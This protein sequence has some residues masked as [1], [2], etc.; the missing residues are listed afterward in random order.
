MRGLCYSVAAFL[1]ASTVLIYDWGWEGLP[2]VI[3]FAFAGGVSALIAY[4]F[5]SRLR[6][7]GSAELQTS[8]PIR[9]GLSVVGLS[10]LIYGP[11]VMVGTLTALLIRDGHVSG[12]SMGTFHEAVEISFISLYFLPLTALLGMA[13]GYLNVRLFSPKGT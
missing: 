10:H 5:V 3:S 7:G 8:A 6:I 4:L 1:S 9:F 13:V 11:V 2:I 12:P